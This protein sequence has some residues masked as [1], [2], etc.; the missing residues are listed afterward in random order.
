MITI[1]DRAA[2]EISDRRGNPAIVMDAAIAGL[3]VAANCGHHGRCRS[4]RAD[5]FDSL[6]VF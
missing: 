6:T 2:P 1:I 4:R 5:G 3:A